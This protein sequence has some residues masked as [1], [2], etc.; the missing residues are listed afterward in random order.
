MTDG[1][2]KVRERFE[3]IEYI[4]Q[5]A[6]EGQNDGPLAPTSGENRGADDTGS[7]ADEPAPDDGGGGHEGG[8]GIGSLPDDFPVQ[9]LGQVG[10][11]FYFLTARGELRELS[12]G[13]LS[14]R[15]NLVELMVGAKDPMGVLEQLAKPSGKRDTGFNA[16]VA[17][18]KLMQACAELPLFDQSMPMRHFGTWRAG[19]AVPVV[20]LGERV[21][22]S[23]K[24]DRRGR[25]IGRALYPAVP[26]RSAPGETP[27]AAVEIEW[28]RDRIGRFWNWRSGDSADL[29]IG[30]IGQAALGHYPNWRTHMWIKGKHGSGKSTLIE[31][32]SA[33]LGG[34]SPGVKNSTSAAAMRQTTNR[35]AVARIFDEAEKKDEPGGGVEEVIAL[36]RLMSGS[37]GAQVERGTSD[38]A[39][40]RFELFGAGLLGSIIPGGMAPQDQSRFVLVALNARKEAENPEDAALRLEELQQ[41]AKELGP[42]VWRRMLDLAPSRWDRTF[43]IY[44]STVQSLGGASRA[45]DTIG[46]ILAG[47]DLMLFDKPLVCPESGEVD[48]ERMARAKEMAQPL[49]SQTKEADEE[50]EG[51]RFLRTLRGAQLNKDHGGVATVE[52]QLFLLQDAQ[53][54][55]SPVEQKLIARLGLRMLKGERGKRDL[56][57]ANGENPLLNQALRGTRWRAGGHRAALETIPDVKPSEKPVRVAGSARRGMIVP[58]RFLPG[59]DPEADGPKGDQ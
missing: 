13:A 57:I 21:L 53:H 20:H 29:V 56:F 15:S 19:T 51:E 7:Q 32:I 41:D 18:D 55:P 59:I 42:H 54:D 27:A 40:I 43:R 45:G 2:D 25:K 39:G 48:Q 8:S 34:M 35:M 3:Q 17:A 11:K 47:W 44:S 5:E 6:R 31:I 30:W 28:V 46:A 58:A 38:H 26:S 12:A 10:S 52:E 16:S 24:E 36:F 33:L 49:I 23:A 22:A 9:P 37:E 1:A 50:G 14:Y 4:D